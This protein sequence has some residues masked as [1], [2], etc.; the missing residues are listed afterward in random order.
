M[1]K[2]STRDYVRCGLSFSLVH[3]IDRA[4]FALLVVAGVVATLESVSI[5]TVDS[6]VVVLDI[7][8]ISLRV[9]CITSKLDSVWVPL[10]LIRAVTSIGSL[11]LSISSGFLHHALERTMTHFVTSIAL[12][13]V[14]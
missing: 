6:V 8:T 1:D 9:R 13:K 14:S 11:L 4:R 3:H 5:T 2:K 12:Y 10:L 7:S